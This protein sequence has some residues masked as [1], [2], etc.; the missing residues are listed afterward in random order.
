MTSIWN[1]HE[2]AYP[3]NKEIMLS[4]E[5]NLIN[6]KDRQNF[7]LSDIEEDATISVTSKNCSIEMRSVEILIDA[8][9][10]DDGRPK[11]VYTTSPRKIYQV[12]KVLASITPTLNNAL[13]HES[14]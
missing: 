11:P 8:A 9:H 7:L 5:G 6:K 13:L 10:Q 4:W 3:S 1:P 14:L 12:S 2:K